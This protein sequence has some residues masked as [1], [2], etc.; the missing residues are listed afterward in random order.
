MLLHHLRVEQ[1][2]QV[3]VHARLIESIVALSDSE[4]YHTTGSSFLKSSFP[5]SEL[6]AGGKRSSESATA[7]SPRGIRCS[8]A[9]VPNRICQ[10]IPTQIRYTT[11]FALLARLRI[12]RNQL[13]SPI[14]GPPRLH[15]G[16]LDEDSAAG[17]QLLY[18]MPPDDTAIPG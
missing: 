7:S 2:L 12:C 15:I 18:Y 9:R 3:F 10:L 1:S 14:L 4:V 13:T 6:A 17:E 8:G 16:Y 11:R 5:E